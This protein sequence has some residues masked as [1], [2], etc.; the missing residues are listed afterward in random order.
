[1]NHAEKMKTSLL[2]NKHLAAHDKAGVDTA[3]FEAGRMVR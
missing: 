3:T 1:M 2:S